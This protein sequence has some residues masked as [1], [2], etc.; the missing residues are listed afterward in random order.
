MAIEEGT[1]VQD[2]QAVLGA[3]AHRAEAD[4]KRGSGWFS[5][6][7][8]AGIVAKGVSY[9][10]V[11][12][13]ALM[14]AL[15]EGGK[16]TSREGALATLAQEPF[17][18]ALLALLAAGFVAYALWRLMLAIASDVSDDE[19]LKGWGER[20]VNVV[21]SLIY[22]ALTFGALKILIGSAGGQSET[23]KARD[24]TA[25]ILSWPAGTWLVGIVGLVIVGVGLWNAYQGITKSF[26][27][28]W[29]TG[30]MS[31][32][33]QR[34][35]RRA[36][37]AGHLSRAVVFSMIGIFVMKAAVEY[38]PREAIGLDGA[39]TKLAAAPYGPYLLGIAAAGLIS[40][41]IYCLVDARYTDVSAEG[42]Q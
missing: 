27:D 23:G 6:I 34:W 12:I 32:T 3:S 36:G 4:A 20:G 31:Q 10:I 39:L 42:A 29:R 37:V 24:T 14:L 35:G 15:G 41:A 8:R 11:G 13:L 1:R 17:G 25:A 16:A 21:R 7:A 2:G 38:E 30:Q 28:D 9:G 26:E 40:Y 22:A 33:A 5:V 18:K 19:K